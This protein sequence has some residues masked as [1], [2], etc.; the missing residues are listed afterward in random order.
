M[1]QIFSLS[2][3]EFQGGTEEKEGT[4]VRRSWGKSYIDINEWNNDSELKRE[5]EWI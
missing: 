5:S 3:I 4:E 1:H 2:F